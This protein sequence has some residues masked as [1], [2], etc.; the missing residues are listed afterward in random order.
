[1]REKNDLPG[2]INNIASRVK[3]IDPA[4]SIT[5][6]G[7]RGECEVM[8]TGK[9]G[10]DKHFMTVKAGE[11]DCR[12]LG[13]IKKCRWEQR[14]IEEFIWKM[15]RSEDDKERA[16]AKKLSNQ[17]EDITLDKFN[18]MVGI[19]QFGCGHWTR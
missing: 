16:M 14:K 4:F 7:K 3:E 1:M 15:E 17:V 12:V 10:I 11:L 2:D 8:E 18:Q 13:H 19:S 6:N 9:D 5:W